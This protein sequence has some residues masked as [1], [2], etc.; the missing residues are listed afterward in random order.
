EAAI[1]LL[2]D[3]LPKDPVSYAMAYRPAYVGLRHDR[4]SRG[5]VEAF[6]EARM[7]IWVYTPN[8]V[9]DITRA[10]SAGV[11]GVISDYPERIPL[12]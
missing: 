7:L 9:A 8:T 4:A 11:D 10:L 3:K 1:M 2:F 6:H 5:L 12:D